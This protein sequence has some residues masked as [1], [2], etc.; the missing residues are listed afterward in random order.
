MKR[1]TEKEYLEL[2]TEI[3]DLANKI[4]NG[5]VNEVQED[6]GKMIRLEKIMKGPLLDDYD[7]YTMTAIRGCIYS[8]VSQEINK[9]FKD[10]D[11]WVSW[12]KGHFNSSVE[13]WHIDESFGTCISLDV[14]NKLNVELYAA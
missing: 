5:I 13:E 10:S 3:R 1:L 8:A 14:L 7:D 6:V 4:S 11:W 2:R 12:Y 9:A